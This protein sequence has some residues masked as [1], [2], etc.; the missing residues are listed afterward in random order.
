[1][2]VTKTSGF[3][4]SQQEPL[5][6]KFWLSIAG[7]NAL[8][9]SDRYPWMIIINKDTGLLYQLT[10]I[11]INSIDYVNDWNFKPLDISSSGTNGKS[12][13]EAGVEYS[14]GDI[15]F[16][17]DRIF[18][19]K[20]INTDKIPITNN[21]VD[22]VNWRELPISV[23]SHDRNKDVRLAKYTTMSLA[24]LT[25]VNNNSIG[26][27]N[28]N[29]ILEDNNIIELLVTNSTLVCGGLIIDGSN[30]IDLTN[31]DISDIILHFRFIDIN[32]PNNPPTT[33]KSITFKDASNVLSTDTFKMYL[34]GKDITFTSEDGLVGQFIHF[35]IDTLNQ[36]ILYNSSKGIA[37]ENA[38]TSDL[39][40]VLKIIT[41]LQ[42]PT[43]NI[44][45]RYIVNDKIYEM[46]NGQSY[47]KVLECSVLPAGKGIVV[48]DPPASWY[49][50]NGTIWEKD[51][52][53]NPTVMDNIVNNLNG[54][55]TVYN[56]FTT[57]L[58][59]DI[60]QGNAYNK[61]RT[62]K[63]IYDGILNHI[64]NLGWY[65]SDKSQDSPNT[66]I[67]GSKITIYHVLKYNS[68]TNDLIWVEAIVPIDKKKYIAIYNREESLFELIWTQ[69]YPIDIAN[70]PTFNLGDLTGKQDYILTVDANGKVIVKD[71]TYSNT[72]PVS[73]AFQGISAGETF[74]KVP[75]KNML[76]KIIYK[77]NIPIISNFIT[78]IPTFAEI[79]GNYTN[80]I[81][82]SW[83]I[84][85]IENVLIDN[86]NNKH[87]T[88]LDVNN[89][90]TVI[91]TTDTFNGTTFMYISNTNILSTRLFRLQFYDIKGTLISKDITV[92]GVKPIYFGANI[93]TT[94]I[95]TDI[96]ALEKRL[97][98]TW[99]TDYN[100][101][102][103][104][105]KYFIIP[106]STG[107]PTLFKDANTGF[108]I[109][110]ENPVSIT[111][112]HGAYNIYRTTNIL[113]SA[114]TITI[115]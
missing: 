114:I 3:Y 95:D 112:S 38:I 14:I 9:L 30:G 105:Y 31:P 18:E 29:G 4:L 15:K 103:G 55:D 47:T 107:T 35:K 84:Q 16:Y 51:A 49:I 36:I 90:N 113:N 99:K 28:I 80:P 91:V 115:S 40:P 92:N 89:G 42:F 66:T 19:S 96:Y 45:D 106:V 10:P 17:A 83:T 104:G 65:W 100:Y 37:N 79:N 24:S 88:I 11:N 46:I 72:V 101:I 26:G 70:I 111:L 82:F 58:E 109:A 12:Q 61:I 81:S 27:L 94:L 60:W 13:W 97:H 43:N 62:S 44:G 74:N 98:T 110:M 25:T 67:D 22:S 39:A 7:M 86:N 5:D 87:I 32:T 93:K 2:S 8:P 76:D 23:K 69:I 73:T 102:A 48:L 21:I 57:G 1:M 85:N 50:W 20:T 75:I 63:Y 6:S 64:N 34:G 71:F 68:P 56:R 33:P 78:S 54:N 53:Y 108:Q 52:N 77:Y 59:Q 41:T